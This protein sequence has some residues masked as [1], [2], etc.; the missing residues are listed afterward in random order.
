MHTETAEELLVLAGRG[1][2]SSPSQLN[3]SHF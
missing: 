2:H 3:V 1:L